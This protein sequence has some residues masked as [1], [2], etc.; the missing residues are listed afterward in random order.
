MGINVRTDMASEAH[1]ILAEDPDISMPSGVHAKDETVNGFP[2]YSVMIDSDE[3]SRALNKPKGKY[4]TLE[5]ERFFQHSSDSFI[6]AAETIAQLIKSCFDMNKINSV[7]IAALG[8][9]DIT[10]DALGPLTASNIIVTRHLKK[11]DEALFSSFRSVSLVRTGVLGTSGIESAAHIK[12]L[13]D[14]IGPDLVIAVD[15]MAGADKTRLCRTVQI[16][17]S[18]IAPGSGVGNDREELSYEYLGMPVIGIGIPT[19]IDASF[20][21]DENEYT[22]MFVTPR[23]I[24]SIVRCAGRLIAY[25]INLALH[26]GLTVSDIDMLIS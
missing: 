20:F 22:G 4:Y 11:S 13:C 24:D 26:D 3:G 10:P 1:R 6:P 14:K 5:L 12:T 16:G 17:S 21:C 9:P 2:L 18:G 19:V 15:A 8:N 7:L 23:N 25:G